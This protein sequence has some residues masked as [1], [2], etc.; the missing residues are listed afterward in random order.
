VSVKRKKKYVIA[1]PPESPVPP[2][3]RAGIV[4]D[5]KDSSPAY[6]G[7]LP[8]RVGAST[9]DVAR[10]GASTSD[11]S[12]VGASTPDVKKKRKYVV[13]APED[14]TGPLARTRQ[15][16][17]GAVANR[18]DREVSRSSEPEREKKRCKSPK[19]LRNLKKVLLAA[20]SIAVSIAVCYAAILLWRFD[21]AIHRLSRSDLTALSP[22]GLG[23]FN[24]LV[25]GS[26]TRQGQN[27]FIPGDDHPGLADTILVIQVRSTKVKVLSIPR[28][29]RVDLAR[30]GQQKINAALPLGGPSLLIEAVSS[31]TGL[32][33]HHYLALDFYGFVSLT[34]AV[35][36][37][38]LCLERAE[39]DAFSGLSLPAGCH[40]VGGEQALA[41]VRSRHTEIYE[42]GKWVS[43][44]G[45]D[46]SRMKRQQA[47]FDALSRKLSGPGTVSRHGWAVASRLGQ[48]ITAD[49]GFRFYEEI[50]LALA[51]TL[52]SA[53]YYTLPGSP[54]V[55]R[56]VS[57]VE[58]DRS[59]AAE[60]LA[61]FT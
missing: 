57:Y 8:P 45:G 50:R 32:R 55:I 19:G 30:F 6:R 36:G 25:T 34:D 44:P 3:S 47:Y 18:R 7:H 1:P 12:R 60:V 35:G 41:Y 24:I 11:V 52:G 17:S 56:G 43:D 15:A 29:T 26:D 39:R 59:K 48:A 23:T 46:F 20:A 54:T 37:V 14:V 5:S 33:I 31:L 49:P 9:S 61:N 4:R 42:N 10:V 22:G 13:R 21:T 53:E 58:I 16:T 27:V 2:A 40:T 38:E 51:M 28:D